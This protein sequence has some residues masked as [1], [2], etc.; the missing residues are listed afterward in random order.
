MPIQHAIWKIGQTPAALLTS[1]LASE[2]LLE[3]M[4]V[5]R[6]DES[7]PHHWQP[8]LAPT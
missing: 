8:L 2:Q 7:L 1:R 3:D 5:S 6:V 4:I